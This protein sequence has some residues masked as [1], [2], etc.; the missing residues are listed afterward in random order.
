MEAIGQR[1]LDMVTLYGVKLLL[2]L[3]NTNGFEDA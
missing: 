1:L 3:G 2:A